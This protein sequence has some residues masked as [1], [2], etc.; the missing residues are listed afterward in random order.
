MRFTLVKRSFISG[1]IMMF[2]V[3]IAS[4]ACHGVTANT[5]ESN[6]DCSQKKN[7]FVFIR[8]LPHPLLEFVLAFCGPCVLNFVVTWRIDF[9]RL[10]LA[11]SAQKSFSVA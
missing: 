10:V 6:Q 3:R 7:L 8:S 11:K 2:S 5:C 9:D 1:Q 4:H